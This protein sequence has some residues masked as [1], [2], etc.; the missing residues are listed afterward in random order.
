MAYVYD[1]STSTQFVYANG[2]L[3]QSRTSENSYTGNTSQIIL[4]PFISQ[5]DT[6]F[7]NGYIDKLTFVS[8]VRSDMEILNEATLVAYYAFDGSYNDSGP[9]HINSIIQVSTTFDSKGQSN[10]ALVINSTNLSYFQTTGFY[11][12]GQ[13]NYSYTFSFWIYP[14]INN[15]TILQVSSSSSNWCIPMIGFDKDGYLTVQTSD[16]ESLSVITFAN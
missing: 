14:F 3:D 11:Y 8:H 2:K 7:R 13:S 1:R 15:G 12:L 6:N 9:N 10:Q 16:S 4:G 5:T